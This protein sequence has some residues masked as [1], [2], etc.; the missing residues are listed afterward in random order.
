MSLLE[1]LIYLADTE[2]FVPDDAD[3]AGERVALRGRR[4]DLQPIVK[5]ATW[6]GLTFEQRGGRWCATVVLDV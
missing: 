4:T 3:V 2:S 5:A 6:H 1:E